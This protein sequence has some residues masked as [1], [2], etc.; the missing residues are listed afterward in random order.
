MRKTLILNSVAAI[1]TALKLVA[2]L[3]I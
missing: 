3:P 1:I 2:A